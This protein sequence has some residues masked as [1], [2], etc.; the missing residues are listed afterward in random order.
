MITGTTVT[1]S[2]EGTHTLLTRVLDTAGNASDWRTDTI[3]IDKTAPAMSVSCGQIAWRSAPASCSVSA[4]GGASGMSTLTGARN[5]GAADT[6]TN[7]L[8]TVDAE[9]S[10]TLSFRAVDGAGN[11]TVTTADVKIDRT[12]PAAAVTCAAGT[13]TS[14]LCRATGSDAISG[15]S[16]LSYSVNG[17]AASALAADGTF[18]VQKGKVVVFGADAAGNVGASAP[19]TLADRTPPPPAPPAPPA[20]ETVTPRTTSEAVLLRGS[21]SAST[22]LLG[23][24]SLSS[25]P[26]K[27]TVDLRPLALGKGK[28]QFVFK[29]TTG[30]KSKTITKTQAVN[31]TG[32]S[33]RISV[34]VSAAAAN[35]KVT[36]TV[37]RRS[38]SRW[39]AYATGSAKLS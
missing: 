28:F 11:E 15:L 23:Q 17:A 5:G 29:V 38:G 12:P 32:Y 16:A 37:R 26:T 2:A 30:K 27:T 25:T 24:L 10:S 1:V 31:K 33:Q 9:G 3:G 36:L 6:V 39:I 35:A 7:S 8:Y 20:E 18:T 22:R 13:G 34:S 19:I 14:Y 4:D 21:G